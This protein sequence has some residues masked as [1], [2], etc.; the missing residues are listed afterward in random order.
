MEGDL[1]GDGDTGRVR[2]E[3]VAVGWQIEGL[4]EKPELAAREA[5]EFTLADVVIGD[6]RSEVESVCHGVLQRKRA[7]R[8]FDMLR[9]PGSRLS[10]WGKALFGGFGHWFVGEERRQ[11]FGLARLGHGIEKPKRFWQPARTVE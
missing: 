2:A 1:A 7:Q 3:I 10:G 6:G 11:S 4:C 8:S 5:M 9:R